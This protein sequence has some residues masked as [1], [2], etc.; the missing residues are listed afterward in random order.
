MARLDEILRQDPLMLGVGLCG[1]PGA[2]KMRSTLRYPHPQ[3]SKLHC[4]S[5][6]AAGSVTNQF[7]LFFNLSWTC[8]GV[9]TPLL[10]SDMSSA[11]AAATKGVAM[12]VPW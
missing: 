1:N 10:G 6:L 11:A 7:A 4:H 8:V 2:G 5:A 12:D 3:V 9:D